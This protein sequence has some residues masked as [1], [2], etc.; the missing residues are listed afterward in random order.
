M[1][2]RLVAAMRIT[3]SFISKPSISTRSWFSVCSRSSWPPPMP[4]PRWRP[5]ASISSMKM[6]QGEFCLACS[7]RSRTR[8]APTPTNISTKSEPEIEKNGTPASPATAR[9]R[10]V[11]PVP[12]GPKSRTPFGMRAPSAWN[13]FGFSRNS[14][15]SWS[16]S[17]ASSTPATSLNVILGESTDIR[18]ARL[19]PKLI[20]LEPPPC[21]W[22]ISRI[23][24]TKNRRKGRIVISALHQGEPPALAPSIVTPASVA[25]AS[26]VFSRSGEG[27]P[28]LKVL[29]GFE[30]SLKL[31][32]LFAGSDLSDAT[33]WSLVYWTR[34]LHVV[35][36]ELDDEL[37][38]L[39]A[40]NA[41]TTTTRI[42]KRALLKSLFTARSP[43]S[44]GNLPAACGPRECPVTRA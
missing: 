28:T 4:A 17:T 20:T 18:L 38:I 27:T 14:L 31:T 5:T 19:L 21:I 8:L 42:G 39:S 24:I 25:A 1:S 40:K 30:V 34:S 13:F 41:S 6:M 43:A 36:R 35:G 11:L 7:N 16:S 37:M 10:S 12:G 15:I 29:S 9:A 33:R 3:L 22:F 2:G 23:Q 26:S 32:L 44:P